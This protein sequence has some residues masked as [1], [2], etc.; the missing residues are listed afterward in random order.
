MQSVPRSITYDPDL[1][2]LVINPIAEL[3]RCNNNNNDNDN[4][5]DNDN[6]NHNE[7]SRVT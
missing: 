6:N 4:G 7:V 2:I 5:N 1:E 3:V